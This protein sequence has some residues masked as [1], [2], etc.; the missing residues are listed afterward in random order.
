M[1]NSIQVFDYNAHE[2]RTVNKDGEVWFVAKDVCDILEMGTEQIR[3]LDDDEKGLHKTQ[4]P[5]G[6]Q[7]MSII[8]EPGLYDL[9][10]RSNKPE[11]RKF[12]RWVRHELLP[13]VLRTGNY[14]INL[15]KEQPALPFGVIDGAKII[16]ETAGI[17]GNQMTL[18]LDKIY[19][20]YTGRS[21]LMSAGIELKAPVQE[22]ALTPT[23]IA[24]TLGIGKGNQGAHIVNV[25]L[26]NA[27]YQRQV[28]KKRKKWEPTE[29]GKPYAYMIDANKAHSNGT[30]II[31]VKWYTS[32]LDIVK[33]LAQEMSANLAKAV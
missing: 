4:T 13:Q 7:E 22:Q 6:I 3:R 28:G 9:V 1:T 12:S 21:A 2:V 17:T 32:I 23:Q 14:S 19:H 15:N 18:A 31:Q 24:E 10:L 11:A 30:P 8:S 27:G 29:L 25:L 26:E 20:S 5:G 33:K 16:F